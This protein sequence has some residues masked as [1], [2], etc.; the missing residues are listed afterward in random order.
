[1]KIS[2][3][4]IIA[5]NELQILLQLQ[6]VPGVVKLLDTFIENGKRVLVM[7]KLYHFSYGDHNIDLEIIRSTVKQ[8]LQTLAFIHSK[9]IVHLD[10]NP[11]NICVNEN[12][13]IVIIDFG[14]AK[15]I[16]GKFHTF[17][18]TKGYI[19]PELRAKC[20]KTTACDIFSVGCILGILLLPHLNREF[21]AAMLGREF[22]IDKIKELNLSNNN[23]ELRDA[24]NLLV[25]M[26]NPSELQRITAVHALQMQFLSLKMPFIK[27]K[28]SK[29]EK[30]GAI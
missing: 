12:S 10:I 7:P 26:I 18:G 24:I 28:S 8:L 11:Y 19:A 22:E 14:A 23:D 30:Y 17:Y 15:Y 2:C 25:E 13:Q 29:K 1:L 5:E 21:S 6:Q 20:A 9:N 4:D 16:D 27:R 3:D